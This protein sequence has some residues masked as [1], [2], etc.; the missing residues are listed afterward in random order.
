MSHRR[1]WRWWLRVE[2]LRPRHLFLIIFLLAVVIRM[3]LSLWVTTYQDLTRYEMERVA[4][5]F[6]REGTLANP[7]YTPTGP[8]AHV[9][10]V[11]PIL[12]GLIFRYVGEGWGGELVKELLSVS[13]AGALYGLLPFVCGVL[14]V[15]RRAGLVAGMAGALFPLKYSTE[16]IGDWEATAAA[17]VLML[18]TWATVATWRHGLFSYRRGAWEG[19]L[20]G[21]GMLVASTLL[22]VFAGMLLV[23]LV[24]AGRK[25]PGAWFRYAAASMAAAAICLAPWAWRNERQLGSPIFAR[26]NSGIELHLSNN[27]LAGPLEPLN[28][29]RGVYF[30][31][32][33]LQ[34]PAEARAVKV[35]GEVGY[36]Q[37]RL[38]Q[39]M[40]WIRTHPGRFLTLTAQR[41]WYTWFPNTTAPGRDGILWLLTLGWLAGLFIL[42]RKDHLGALVLIAVPAFYTP[43]FYLIHV[44]VRHR[45]PVDWL[46]LLC[47]C[48]FV[49]TALERAAH[50]LEPRYAALCFQTSEEISHVV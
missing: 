38:N 8:T 45:Y 1:L 48:Y 39:A 50:L 31:F 33:P 3:G 11:Y 40:A 46:L 21:V 7:Y 44:N 5:S 37:D 23:G 4:I 47:A 2:C 19:L 13:C 17:L 24:V 32:H 22:S 34:N 10:P 18:L 9:P 14:G 36:N 20:W 29:K 26:S 35:M 28:Y 27:D 16:V 12:M 25:D 42:W 49:V 30:A 41:F 43:V 15:G 6:A